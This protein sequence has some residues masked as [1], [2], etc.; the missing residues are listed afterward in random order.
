MSR[1]KIRWGTIVFRII[2]ALFTLTLIGI[3]CYTLWH[4]WHYLE[5]FE[6]Y[7]PETPIKAAAEQMTNDKMLFFDKLVF[8]PNEFEK[9]SFAEDYYKEL[10]SGTITYSRNGKE[11]DDKK[12]VYIL[13]S[14]GKNIANITVEP[15]GSY[16]GYGF[17]EYEI[18]NVRLGTVVT[19][20]YSVKAPSTAV[21][22]CNG[23]K[24]SESYIT[25]KGAVYDGSEYFHNLTESFPCDVI[26]TIA[27]FIKEPVFTAVDESGNKLELNNGKFEIAT[28]KNDEPARIALD[29]ARSYSKYIVRDGSFEDTASFIYPGVKLYNDLYGFKNDWAYIHQ[30]YEFKDINVYD[31]VYYTKNAVSVRISYNH[32]LYGVPWSISADGMFSSAADYTVYLVK[33]EDKW[34]VVDLIIN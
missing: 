19:N 31:T 13:K 21:V 30:S 8:N 34:K 20:T 18:T 25:E 23:K 33:S 26:Y 17:S 1:A 9:R 15:V 2:Y 16:I 27:G 28:V 4:L 5:A 22:Y 29:F 12:T 6:R 24:I 7:R 3:V 14:G 11:S 32:C 10:T